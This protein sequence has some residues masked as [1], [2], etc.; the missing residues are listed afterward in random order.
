MRENPHS[1]EAGNTL[2]ELCD[3]NDPRT[4][5]LFWNCLNDGGYPAVI[6]MKIAESLG[7]LNDERIIPFIS[8]RTK[9][10]RVRIGAVRGAWN[11]KMKAAV[12]TLLTVIQTEPDHAKGPL[13]KGEIDKGYLP[14]EGYDLVSAAIHALGYI[15][16]S[17]AVPIL[18]WLLQPGNRNVP[19]D[20]STPDTTPCDYSWIAA[21]ALADIED[22]SAIPALEAANANATN[23]S[24]RRHFQEAL[25][26]LRKHGGRLPVS[27]DNLESR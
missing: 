1:P 26:K 3:L 12:D 8:D 24:L 7:I 19:N 18:I 2:W 15:G 13:A 9:P 4:S 27:P 22:P 16:D 5:D 23:D 21:G 14:V 17:R 25:A 11:S 20:E 6:R 10:M